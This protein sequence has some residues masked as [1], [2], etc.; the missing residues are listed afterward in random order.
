[1]SETIDCGTCQHTFGHS[2]E[3]AH[4]KNWSQWVRYEPTGDMHGLIA[5]TEPK[6]SDAVN[7]PSHYTFGAIECKDA[8][9]SALTPEEWR[10]Y[11]KGNAIKY[12][13]RERHKGGDESLEKAAVYLDWIR[14]ASD[15]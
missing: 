3:C 10:G 12:I 1:M 11:C 13:W 14:E 6:K 4:C 2:R 8:I 15:E 5:Q 9:K 7:H